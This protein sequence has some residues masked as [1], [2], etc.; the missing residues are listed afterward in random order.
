MFLDA[1]EGI[2][3]AWRQEKNFRFHVY[4]ALLTL[5]IS[6]LLNVTAIEFTVIC[7]V[8]GLV[9]TAET[10]NT[11]LEELCDKFQPEHD[12]H[13]GRI[14]DLA[15]GAVFLATCTAVVVGCVIFIPHLL[16]AIGA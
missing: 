11:A 8:I 6:W 10:F 3:I 12:P 5:A 2:R 9:L 7:T 15:A 13:I 16:T 14:K 1:L 4:F